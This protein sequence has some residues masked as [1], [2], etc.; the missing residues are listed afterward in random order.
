MA[1]L[2][3][4]TIK[5]IPKE[6]R[7]KLSC[8]AQMLIGYIPMTKLESIGNKAAHHCALTN[9]FY[10]CIQTLLGLITSHGKTGLPMMSR[11]G[12]WCQCHPIV[13]N[14]ISDYPEQVL[15]MDPYYGE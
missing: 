1:H 12:I 13:A 11:N 10:S 7:Q 8:C 4:I 14:F 15:V 9:L 3:Y 5:D 6:I 2:V